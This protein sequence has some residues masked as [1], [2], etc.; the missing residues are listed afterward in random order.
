MEFKK[1]THSDMPLIWEFLKKEKGKTTDFSYG[2]VLMWIDYFQYEY[3]VENATL[4]IKGVVENDRSKVAFSLP[5]G[6]NPFEE[7]LK[8]LQDYCNHQNIHLEFSAIPE[9]ALAEIETTHPKSIEELTDCG[10][11]LYDIDSLAT[12]AGKKMSKKRNHVHQFLSA[13][14]D[15]TYETLTAINSNKA[16]E[17]M[18]LFDKEGDMTP[19][20]DAERKLNR[21]LLNEINEGDSNLEGGILFADGKV[22]AFTIGD[23]KSDTLYVHVEKATRHIPGS[24]EMINYVFAQKMKEKY[25]QLEYV[26]REDD[27]GDLGLRFAKESYHPK[28]IL[29]KYNI[30]Y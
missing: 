21:Q 1:I 23:I 11:Y 16:M 3:A 24:Y 7:S 10:D 27:A 25:P 20:A 5:I 28:E 17:F 30:I 12:L 6:P 8:L 2:G 9:Y 18:D 19:Q 14:P 4:F 26:N 22:C 13:F 15:W 29:K